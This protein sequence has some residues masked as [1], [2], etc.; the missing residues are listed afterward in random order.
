MRT[1][2]GKVKNFIISLYFILIVLAILLATLFNIFKDMT[3]NPFLTFMI[4][5]VVFG[6]V[7]FITHRLSKYFEYDSDGINIVIINRG[8]LLSDHFNYREHKL[9]IEKDKLVGFKLYNYLFFKTLVVYIMGRHGNKR[10]ESF[11]M[12][13]VS[14]KKCKYIKQ[15]LSKIVKHN[16]KLNS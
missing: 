3:K 14:R 2:N 13:L 6:V 8:M 10:K 1:N 16:K 4:I 11:N 12:T 5:V 15:S 7:F 9:E